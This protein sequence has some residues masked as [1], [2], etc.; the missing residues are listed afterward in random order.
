MLREYVLLG[1][2]IA[3]SFSLFAQFNI[4]AEQLEEHVH[5]LASDSLLGRGFGTV[6][7]LTSAKYIAQQYMDAGIEPLNGSYFHR[8][9][10]RQGILNISGTNVALHPTACCRY[11]E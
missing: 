3:S 11:P 1:T 8:F 10:H 6:Q 7:G 9:N 5:I 4:P 2:I